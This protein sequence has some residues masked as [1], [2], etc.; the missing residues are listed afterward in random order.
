[1]EIFAFGSVL[2]ELETYHDP[3][4]DLEDCAVEQRYKAGLWPEDTDFIRLWS[5][6]FE[7]AGREDIGI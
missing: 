3:Y 1:M 7:N 5:L 4:P 6:L 2:Y